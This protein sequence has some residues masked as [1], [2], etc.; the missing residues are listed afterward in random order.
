MAAMVALRTGEGKAD[1]DVKVVGL[2]YDG[3]RREL[4]EYRRD[5]ARLYPV[6]DI[7]PAFEGDGSVLVVYAPKGMRLGKKEQLRILLTEHGD[8]CIAS[9][10]GTYA[11]QVK[12]YAE[13][14]KEY[15]Q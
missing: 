14:L 10:Y 5:A 12:H 3:D 8:D 1:R 9:Y 11:E 13:E 15:R 6:T 4:Q 2:V 7:H